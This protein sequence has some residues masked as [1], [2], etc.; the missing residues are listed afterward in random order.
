MSDHIGVGARGEVRVVDI[1]REK[2]ERNEMKEG[3]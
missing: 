2:D 1:P 3:E